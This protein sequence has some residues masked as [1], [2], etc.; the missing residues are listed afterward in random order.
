MKRKYTNIYGEI[1]FGTKVAEF[2]EIGGEVGTNCSIQA[3][4]FIPPGVTIMNNVFIGPGTVFT[5][6]KHPKAQGKWR[7]WYTLVENDVSIGAN[8]TILPG[9]EIHK[10]AIIGAGSVVTKDVPKGGLWIGNKLV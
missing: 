4:V 8:C 2:V 6:D 1:G 7:K 5:N 3:F 10:G 9:V